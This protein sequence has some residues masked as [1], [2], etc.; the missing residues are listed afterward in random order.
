MLWLCVHCCIML[1]SLRKYL[2]DQDLNLPRKHF[3]TCPSAPIY[4][5]K[6]LLFTVFIQNIAKLNAIP[7][8]HQL[9]LR[10][11]LSHISPESISSVFCP[12]VFSGKALSVRKL[13]DAIPCTKGSKATL[14]HSYS[15]TW[16]LS[17]REDTTKCRKSLKIQNSFKLCVKMVHQW[18]NQLFFLLP[19]LSYI[20]WVGL[21]LACSSWK[22]EENT[23]GEKLFNASLMDSMY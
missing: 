7:P 11:S 21:F 9:C 20:F 12:W 14:K 13:W 15:A 16:R 6:N 17:G 3:S 5:N 23:E 8:L 1:K 19:V 2:P 10:T 4:K 22:S 18:Y